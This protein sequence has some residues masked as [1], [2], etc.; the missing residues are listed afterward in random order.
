VSSLRDQ[1]ALVTGSSRCDL[2]FARTKDDT[3]LNHKWRENPTFKLQ[4]PP[5]AESKRAMTDDYSGTRSR[6][7]KSSL[8]G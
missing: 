4:S 3:P 2:C 7:R 1:V 6:A 5:W 8:A